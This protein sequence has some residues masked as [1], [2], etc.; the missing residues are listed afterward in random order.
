MDEAL[1]QTICF[2]N[3]VKNKLCDLDT[4][5]QAKMTILDEGTQY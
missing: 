5:P 1:V 3:F 4:F 2:F